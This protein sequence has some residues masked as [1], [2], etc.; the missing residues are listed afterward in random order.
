M[1][2]SAQEAWKKLRMPF[3][4][5]KSA[6]HLHVCRWEMIDID[7]AGCLICGVI[8]HCSSTTCTNVEQTSDSMVCLITGV[9]VQPKLYAEHEYSENVMVYLKDNMEATNRRFQLIETYVEQLLLSRE[10][11]LL[12]VFEREKSLKKYH[13]W[14]TRMCKH[15]TRSQDRECYTCTASD[16]HGT[17]STH[18]QHGSEHRV[19]M[20]QI[21]Q[22]GLHLYHTS[23][24]NESLRKL[25]SKHCVNCI[26]HVMGIACNRLGLAVKDSEMRNFVFGMVFLMRSGVNLGTVCLLPICK[27]LKNMLPSENNVGK[28]INFKAKYITDTENRFK[29][30]FRKQSTAQLLDIGIFDGNEFEMDISQ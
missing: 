21:L 10:A 6:F 26:R 11:K 27:H 7:M 17:Y 30:V 15:T 19:N 18:S 3:L 24:F 9:C 25:V 4:L 13:T 14:I 29:Y 5:P 20:V 2:L 22:V 28:Y 8:H 12:S 23:H 1:P 16:S